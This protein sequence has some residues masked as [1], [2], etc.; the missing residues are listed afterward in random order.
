MTEP[1]IHWQSS[2]LS[3]VLLMIE[4]LRINR[5][6]AATENRRGAFKRFTQQELNDTV[7]GTY[8]NLLIGRS[9][10]LPDRQM[11]LDIADYLECT[12][13]DRNDLLLA[14]GYV[15]VP[16]PLSGRQLELALDQARALM[17]QLPYPAMIVT[18]MLDVSGFNPAFSEL[19]GISHTPFTADKM[20]TIDF[21]FN[22]ELPVRFRSSF[23]ERSRAR[24]ESHAIYGIQA[25]KKAHPAVFVDPWY[26]RFYKMMDK[27][28]DIRK[29]WNRESLTDRQ[30]LAEPKYFL[31][32]SPASSEQKAIGYNQLHMAVTAHAYPRIEFFVPADEPA[33]MVFAELDCATDCRW[34]NR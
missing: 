3:R 12:A 31:A 11:L 22:S 7:C 1:Y 23:D 30:D 5:Q 18:D 21:H 13:E 24:W 19:F 29:Y 16:M 14:A 9:Q 27:Y 20:N 15:P 8:K 33:R 2:E 34:N 25:F 17:Q 6:Q 32:H 10:R 4:Q 28:P 26:D